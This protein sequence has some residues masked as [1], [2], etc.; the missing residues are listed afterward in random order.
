MAANRTVRGNEPEMESGGLTMNGSTSDESTNPDRA[1][2]M[3]ALIVCSKA[4]GRTELELGTRAASP[5]ALSLE[6][7]ADFVDQDEVPLLVSLSVPSDYNKIIVA[8]EPTGLASRLRRGLDRLLDASRWTD[9]LSHRL[10]VN[11]AS[12]K[13]ARDEEPETNR[14]AASLPEI[15]KRILDEYDELARQLLD[16]RDHAL[17]PIRPEF[18]FA[19]MP[20]DENEDRR[21]EEIMARRFP[22]NRDRLPVVPTPVIGLDAPEPARSG[23]PSITEVQ[24]FGWETEV[25]ASVL[26][27]HLHDP[28]CHPGLHWDPEQIAEL[29]SRILVRYRETSR[30]LSSDPLA[31]KAFGWNKSEGVVDLSKNCHP[32]FNP[33]KLQTWL[34]KLHGNVVDQHHQPIPVPKTKGGLSTNPEHWEPWAGCLKEFLA[35]RDLIRM[36]DLLRAITRTEPWRP[37]YQMLPAF[38]S[39]EPNLAAISSL[40]IT[41]FRPSS[42]F[43]FEIVRFPHLSLFCLFEFLVRTG[44]VH[45]AGLTRWTELLGAKQPFGLLAESIRR[46]ESVSVSPLAATRNAT[47]SPPN[48]AEILTCELIFTSSLL[49]M[50]DSLLVTYLKSGYD[51]SITEPQIRRAKAVFHGV[52]PGYTEFLEDAYLGSLASKTGV[53]AQQVIRHQYSNPFPETAGTRARKRVQRGAKPFSRLPAQA[54]VQSPEGGGT[55]FNPSGG[56]SD[57]GDI[58]RLSLCGRPTPAG[59]SAFVN[60]QAFLLSVNDFVVEVAAALATADVRVVAVMSKE[61][62]CEVSTAEDRSHVDRLQTVCIETAKKLF[63]GCRMRI[64]FEDLERF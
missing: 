41:L 9:L 11:F 21:N 40:G 18:H 30:T 58:R 62:V 61:I 39:R 8:A 6:A 19:P 57:G 26:L 4:D 10:L 25:R 27:A 29:R 1:V 22:S 2:D 16:L 49:G 31:S 13:L 55:A 7:F 43:R 50:A 37:R 24:R 33:T 12:S 46:S 51:L 53:S 35:W 28:R 45:S 23:T 5:T 60:G 20:R 56:R 64:D 34:R 36:A 32:V 42:G 47:T 63:G 14:P 17:R 48:P 52:V 59:S 15:R 3:L 54:D 44:M 38:S